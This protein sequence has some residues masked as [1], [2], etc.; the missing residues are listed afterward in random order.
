MREII[1]DVYDCTDCNHKKSCDRIIYEQ[2]QIPQIAVVLQNPGTPP[3]DIKEAE[4]KSLRGMNNAEKAAYH[5]GELKKWIVSTSNGNQQ[6]FLRFFSLLYKNNLIRSQIQNVQDLKMYVDSGQVFKDVYFT[7]GLKCRGETKD[8]SHKHFKYCMGKYLKREILA[9]ENLKLLFVFS[10]RSWEAFNSVYDLKQI[11][12]SKV[13]SKKVAQVHGY[14]FRTEIGVEEKN[15]NRKVHVI[16]LVHMSQ[17][18][19]NNTLRDSY[20]DY[21]EEGMEY[22]SKVVTI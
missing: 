14:V 2:Q 10:T 20:F 6:F 22:F 4:N 21:L 9:L 17:V 11:Q 7:D 8:F 15:E 16:P 12:V 5:S 13:E 3:E 19:R 18:S 1:E